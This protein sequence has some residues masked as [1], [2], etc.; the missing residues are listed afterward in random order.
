VDEPIDI[1]AFLAHRDPDRVTAEIDAIF[2]EASGRS[3]EPGPERDAFRERWL[4]RYLTHDSDHAFLAITADGSTVGYLVGALDDP[5]RASRFADLPYFRALAAEC[6]RFP[7]HL[8]INLASSHR[9]RGIGARLIEAFVAHA[10]RHGAAGVHVVTGVGARNV[11]FYRA[12]GFEPVAETV[13]LGV[14]R[15]MLARRLVA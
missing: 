13:W 12:C 5:A 1:V 8:H 9:G 6:A 7:A 10:I 2:F 14:P 15:L 4:G 11:R 3:F